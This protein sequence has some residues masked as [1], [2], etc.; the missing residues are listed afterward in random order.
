MFA[1]MAAPLSTLCGLSV[2]KKWL[3]CRPVSSSLSLF[4]DIKS[5]AAILLECNLFSKIYICEAVNRL[6]IGPQLSS[7]GSGF[8]SADGSKPRCLIYAETIS[9]SVLYCSFTVKLILFLLGYTLA[10][11]KL[12]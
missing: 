1:T 2:P 6:P 11:C 4:A 9:K 10:T 3:R 5:V 7:V 12:S 8:G